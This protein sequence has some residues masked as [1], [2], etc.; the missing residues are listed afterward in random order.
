MIHSR[1][2]LPRSGFTLVELL[3]VIAI[4]GILVGLLLPAVQAAREAARRMQCSN[5]L[6]QLGLA[7]LNYES[8]HKRFPMGFQFRGHYDGN[9]TDGDGGTG[10]G[11]NAMILPFIE[12]GNMHALIDFRFPFFNATLGTPEQL[13]NNEAIKLTQAWAR[14]PSDIAP[15][16]RNYGGSNPHAHTHCITSYTMNAGS[17]HNSLGSAYTANANLINGI[18]GRDWSVKIGEVTDGTSNTFIFNERTYKLTPDTTL[19]GMINQS[20]GFANGRVSHVLS[21]GT[22]RMNPVKL[23]AWGSVETSA[24]SLHVGGANFTRCDGSVQFVSENIHHTSRGIGENGGWASISADPY[25]AANGN[26]GFGTYQRL[27][28]RSDGLVVNDQ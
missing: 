7:A 13:R 24:H 20:L 19:Y 26:V 14:C 23:P 21:N 27:W 16:T 4:I 17:F 9:L 3:V 8:A 5:N 10:W 11:W 15:E 28:A 25:D 6:K 1:V 12:A 18:G 2:R 22:Y